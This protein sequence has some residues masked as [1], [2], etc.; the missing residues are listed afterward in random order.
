MYTWSFY[1]STAQTDER[2]NARYHGLV[3][4]T[5]NQ[6]IPTLV[7]R[8]P[9]ALKSLYHGRAPSSRRR[10]TS[11]THP[12]PPLANITGRGRPSPS[13]PASHVVA[14]LEVAGSDCGR[15]PPGEATRLRPPSPPST[16]TP[17]RPPPPLAPLPDPLDD[18]R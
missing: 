9:G 15:P 11:P 16:A 12:S 13:F 5:T 10:G 17:N 2:S 4:G 1:H 6:S 18:H 7:R 8:L 14:A 3:V